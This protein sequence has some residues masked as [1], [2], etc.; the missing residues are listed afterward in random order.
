M[1][2]RSKCVEYYWQLW[3]TY[4]TNM[5]KFILR[6]YLKYAVIYCLTITWLNKKYTYFHYCIF[7][8][9]RTKFVLSVKNITFLWCYGFETYLIDQMFKKTWFSS[10]YTSMKFQLDLPLDYTIEITLEKSWIGS[11]LRFEYKEV[12][13]ITSWTYKMLCR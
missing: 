6:T 12:F 5:I 2:T 9:S 13:R 7:R 1:P 8:K 10:F 4:L 11:C 3:S